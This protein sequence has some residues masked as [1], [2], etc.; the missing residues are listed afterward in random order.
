VCCYPIWQ[1]ARS[2]ITVVHRLSAENSM[3]QIG[4]ERGG[5]S[6][7]KCRDKFK[8]VLNLLIEIASYQ[9]S[10]VTLDEKIKVTNRRVNALE[11]VVIPKFQ[12]IYAY[13][14]QEL[15]EQAKEDFYRLK[16]VLDN[17]RRLI[18]EEDEQKKKL[19][20]TTDI[21]DDEK[22]QNLLEEFDEDV[23]F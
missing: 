13:I 4:M 5:Q 3:S 18:Q 12:S 23:I 1:S 17:K 19:M 22:T 6:I 20:A 2:K 7:Q 10:F 16:K 9:A 11:H 8:E 15:D 21:D 14:D